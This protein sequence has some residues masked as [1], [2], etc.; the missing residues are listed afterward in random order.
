MSAKLYALELSHPSQAVRLMLERKG[1]DH[2]VKYLLPGFHP[3]VLRLAGFRGD[4]VPALK[5]DG[6]RLQNSV[7]I[8]RALDEV[9]PDP[10]LYPDDPERRRAVEEA[11]AWGEREFQPVPRRIFRWCVTNNAD[12]RRQLARAIGMPLPNVAAAMNVPIAKH[13]ARKA[14]AGDEQVRTDIQN[15]TA[16]LDHV[17]GLIEAGTIGGTEPN[18]ADFQIGTTARVFLSFEDLAPLL[19]GRPTKELALSILPA[20]VGRTPKV[21]PPEWLAGVVTAP[22]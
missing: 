13:F 7:A 17:D 6:R 18:A 11:E 9:R 10:P 1:I 20:Y 2:E 8:S 4:T 16:L 5:I 22:A 12:L 15:L 19:E 14:G 3:P 21:L